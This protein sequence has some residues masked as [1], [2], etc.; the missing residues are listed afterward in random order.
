MSW[1]RLVPSGKVSNG[2]SFAGLDYYNRLIDALLAE[3]I[4]PFITLFH[5]D[6][7]MGLQED[8]G[9]LNDEIVNHFTDY[10]GIAFL[11]FGDR[12]KF[13]L[14]FNEPQIFCLANWN[15]GESNPF[16]EPPVK[17]YI[18][19]HNVIKAYAKSWRLYNEQFRPT[20][21]GKMGITMNCD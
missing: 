9:W 10:A 16:S 4:E 8:G 18:C 13:W 5:W 6:T 3:G 2:V 12:V 7:P 14:S 15:Y 20:Q 17:P 1:S 21:N 11:A 19:S